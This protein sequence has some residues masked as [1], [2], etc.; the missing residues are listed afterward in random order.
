MKIEDMER[1]FTK[2]GPDKD[3]LRLVTYNKLELIKELVE[4]RGAN[5]NTKHEYGGTGTLHEAALGEE[6]FEKT[7]AEIIK[8]LISKKADVNALDHKGRT[9]LDISAK[10]HS[11]YCMIELLKHQAKPNTQ[12]IIELERIIHVNYCSLKDVITQIQNIDNIR[13]KVLE[14]EESNKKDKLLDKLASQDMKLTQQLPKYIFKK[15]Q[16]GYENPEEKLQDLKYLSYVAKGLEEDLKNLKKLPQKEIAKASLEEQEDLKERLNLM[17]E[18]LKVYLESF[19][20]LKKEKI[21]EEVLKTSDLITPK[22]CEFLSYEDLY[23]MTFGLNTQLRS[24]ILEDVED[25]SQDMEKLAIGETAIE[26]S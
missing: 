3:L 23:K 8:Y 19:C 14:L 7:S 22:I 18:Y 2:L 24:S 5:V 26:E 13:D 10:E 6:E 12:D 4:N 11:V 25:L 20:I 15:D 16:K 21:V 1:Y 17:Q 9:P